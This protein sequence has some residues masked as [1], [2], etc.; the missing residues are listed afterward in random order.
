MTEYGLS[1]ANL[2]QLRRMST[3]VVASAVE[4]FRVR[5]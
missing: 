1:P 5:L 4:T 2:E 3:C